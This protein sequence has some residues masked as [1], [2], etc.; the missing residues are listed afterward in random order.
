MRK[1]VFFMAVQLQALPQDLLVLWLKQ[2]IKALSA[3]Q[4]Q[5]TSE[6][7]FVHVT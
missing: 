5:C 6:R 3:I 4:L 1:S 2:F 7:G